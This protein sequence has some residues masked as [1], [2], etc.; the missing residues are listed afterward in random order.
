MLKDF[1]ETAMQSELD[2][3]LNSEKEDDIDDHI[4]NRRNG[5]SSKMVKTDRG[6]FELNTPKD[7]N[8]SFEP[9]IV[10]KGQTHP[11]NPPTLVDSSL[12]Y[13]IIGDCPKFNLKQSNK[14]LVII[15]HKANIYIALWLIY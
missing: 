1:I 8:S 7:R 12:F 9:K 3:H 14:F 2:D 15:S 6:Q 10:K 13:D 5:F 11:I 4:S